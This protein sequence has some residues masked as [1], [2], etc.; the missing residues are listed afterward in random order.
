MLKKILLTC[1]AAA[2][3]TAAQPA[4]EVASIKLNPGDVTGSTRFD[5][6]GLT[7]RRASLL[8]LISMA[9][10]MPYSRVTAADSRTRE[11]LLLPNYDVIATAGHE[12]PK[13][14]LLQMLQT[15]L[16]DRFQLKLHRDSQIQPVYKLVV[17]KNGP[18]LDVTNPARPP[19]RTCVFP[20]C[21]AVANSEMW[22]FAATLSGRMGRP[23]LD[24]TGLTGA[25]DFSLR[26]DT[27]E[28]L[29]ADDPELKLKMMDWSQSS[30]FSDLE[31]QLGLKLESD[32]AP[33]ETLVVD[34][35]EKPSEN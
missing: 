28:Q 10:E 22:V 5:P 19:D 9:Y 12:V 30:I 26:L 24:Q 7:I 1:L 25:Y 3:A 35:A 4:F 20:K 11:A 14:E 32:K 31:K 21:L 15:L 2:I 16:A 33:V 13:A 6:A 27:F 34:H 17:A 8:L 23:V 29:S 18:K